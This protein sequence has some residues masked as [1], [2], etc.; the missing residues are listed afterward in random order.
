MDQSNVTQRQRAAAM[1]RV[2]AFVGTA[3]V[4]YTLGLFTPNWIALYEHKRDIRGIADHCNKLSSEQTGDAATT[5]FRECFNQNIAVMAEA[6]ET[7][8]ARHAGDLARRLD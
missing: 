7:S 6:A 8:A 4:F 2:I 3:V 5:V 1:K